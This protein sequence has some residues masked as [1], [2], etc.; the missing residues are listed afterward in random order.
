MLD[1]NQ[2]YS[3]ILRNSSQFPNSCWMPNSLCRQQYVRCY[4]LGA[5]QR[6]ANLLDS[7]NHIHHK[8]DRSW[9]Y[10]SL[11]PESSLSSR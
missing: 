7:D 8:Y 5:K 1:T 9:T 11:R 6:W 10:H 3:W 4:W 2:G